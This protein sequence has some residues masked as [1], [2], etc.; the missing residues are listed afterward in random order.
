MFKTVQE[1]YTFIIILT[2][3]LFLGGLLGINYSLLRSHSLATADQTAELL[4]DNADSQIDLLFS[5][6]EALT[7]SLSKQT[8]VKEVNIPRMREL[9]LSNVEVRQDF[10]RA[11]YLGTAD[12]NMYEWG[13]GPGFIDFSPTFPD[14]YDPR[15]RPWYIQAVTHN[16]Y[17]LTDPYIYASVPA[18]G[19]TAVQPVYADSGT[20]IGVLGLD[21]VL[22]GLEY[23]VS[24]LKIQKGGKIVLLTDSYE[25]LVNQFSEAENVTNTLETF[26]HIQ[27]LENGRSNQITV[28]DGKKYLINHTINSKTGWGIVLYLPLEDILSFSQENLK[29]ILFFDIILMMLLGSVV[30]FVSRKTLTEPL[31][32]IISVL[33]RLERGEIEARIPDQSVEEFQLMARLFNSLADISMESSRKME[34]KV[35]ERTR[36][37]IRLQY[38]N[39]RLRIIEEKEHI[40]ANLHDS[41][42]ARLTSINISNH[43]AKSALSRAEYQVLKEMLDRIEKNTQ[44]GILDLKEILTAEEPEE[45]TATEFIDFLQNSIVQRLEVTGIKLQLVLPRLWIFEDLSST[46]LLE[47]QRFIEEL[48]SNALKHSRAHVIKLQFEAKNSRLILHYSDDGVGFDLKEASKRGFG[49]QGLYNRGERLGGFLKIFSKPGKGTR[50]DLHIKMEDSE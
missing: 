14:D 29:I 42:G 16:S 39:S 49:L 15:S 24:S 50:I 10:I 11:L 23:L 45:I 8:A 48:I 18:I 27:F 1:K 7:V 33:H 40:Y 21:L 43:V 47:L 25:I 9:F 38:E 12:G 5:N 20:F 30:T 41:L 19:I 37:V 31:H 36:D 34:E 22:D 17:G 2:V 35:Q 46:I 26:D 44:Q 4:L 13:I 3:T 6:I 32:A 28:K